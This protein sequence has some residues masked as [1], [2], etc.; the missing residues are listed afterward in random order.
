MDCVAFLKKFF[1]E[2]DI[3]LNGIDV[4][5][6][7]R[8]SGE[9]VGVIALEDL[10]VDT[11]VATIPKDA[12]LSTR[13]T[14]I[15]DVLEEAE[16]GGGAALSL[17]LMFE[18]EQGEKSPF[19][20]YLRSLP[21]FETALPFWSPEELTMLEGTEPLEVV[22]QDKQY[23]RED[24]ETLVVPIL[25]KNRDLF[26]ADSPNFTFEA[27][28]KASSIV[29]SRA[30]RVDAFHGDS[31]VP[32]ADAFNHLTDNEHVHLETDED[33]CPLCGGPWPCPQH[34]ELV[35]EGGESSDDE[36]D[37]HAC[38]DP[39]CEESHDEEGGTE[40]PA[41]KQRKSANGDPGG[42]HPKAENGKRGSLGDDVLEPISDD[43]SDEL[44]GANGAS[45][46]ASDSDSDGD[47]ASDGKADD[48]MEMRLVRPA[49]KGDEL[50]NTYGTH[51]NASL[52]HKYGF[53]D[54]GP[55]ENKYDV[56]TV[57]LP[58]VK[59]AAAKA[60]GPPSVVDVSCKLWS[61][62]TDELKSLFSDEEDEDGMQD[63]EATGAESAFFRFDYSGTPEKMLLALL[64]IIGMD[65][66]VVKGWTAGARLPKKQAQAVVSAALS[67][68]EAPGDRIRT[69]LV[70]IAKARLA[71]YP[72]SLSDDE[73][74]YEAAEKQSRLF[75][76][77]TIRISEK[78]ILGR[79]VEQ[80]SEAVV[81][82]SEPAKKRKR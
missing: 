57:S 28:S 23:L 35:V 68:V 75:Q 64:G 1:E 69:A 55:G 26:P 70:E 78:R 27:F 56:V 9:S 21:D 6:G 17:A 61:A 34:A 52:L 73:T 54:D 33:V 2:H 30:F 19:Y 53:V 50:F 4:R 20:N 38:H 51:S 82:K 12:V 15:G 77:L 66:K 40:G 16:L 13:T 22:E 36:G 11:V 74:Q 44:D 58:L 42:A 80:Y 8:G 5:A 43:S 39:D 71:R 76:A 29:A 59:E 31:L 18:R 41:K 49:K 65:S 62:V 32:L 46:T 7:V 47:E 72:T 24:F 10:A 63:A 45:G 60:F 3:K 67:A 79:M 14:A 81:R 25:E 37:G 48:M